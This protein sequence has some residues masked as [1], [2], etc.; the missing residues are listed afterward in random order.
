MRIKKTEICQTCAKLKNVCQT[1][2]LDLAYGLPIKVRD[3]ALGM[4][5]EVPMSDVNKEHY[6]TNA[7]RKVVII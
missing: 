2:I 1:C 5:N 6:I 3:K 7:E 4:K